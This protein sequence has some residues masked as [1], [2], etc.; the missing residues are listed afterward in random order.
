MAH[1]GNII[2]ILVF[3][4]RAMRN[5]VLS[6]MF[7]VLCIGNIFC[8]AW[9]LSRHFVEGVFDWNFRLHSRPVCFFHSLLT[10][11][12]MSFCN[13]LIVCITSLRLF[14]MI[15]PDRSKRNTSWKFVASISTVLT[16]FTFIA[17]GYT[18]DIGSAITVDSNTG[19]LT[20]CELT[21][22]DIYSHISMS[23]FG[24]VP[25]ILLFVLNIAIVGVHRYQA[26][27]Q[28]KHRK[29]S[30]GFAIAAVVYYLGCATNIVIYCF[31]GSIFRHELWKLLRPM[32]KLI[33]LT[34][35]VASVSPSAEASS[36]IPAERARMEPGEEADVNAPHQAMSSGELM[37]TATGPGFKPESFSSGGFMSDGGYNDTSYYREMIQESN[38]RTADK[39]MLIIFSGTLISIGIPGNMLSFRVLRSLYIKR[40]ITF[41]GMTTL[42][43]TNVLALVWGPGMILVMDISELS[44]K[45]KSYGICLLYNWVTY[46]LISLSSWMYVLLIGLRTMRWAGESSMEA[47]DKLVGL[48]IGFLVVLVFGLQAM[49][50]Y[51]NTTY[52]IGSHVHTRCQSSLSNTWRLVNFFS[53]AISPALVLFLINI[54]AFFM[55]LDKLDGLLRTRV[56][57]QV[58]FLLVL[59]N[60]CFMISYLPYAIFAV[61]VVRT[62]TRQTVF[63]E[64]RSTMGFNITYLLLYFNNATSYLLF[65]LFGGKFRKHMK[66]VMYPIRKASLVA[67][68]HNV[69]YWNFS[70]PNYT[71]LKK[72]GGHEHSH[73][74]RGTSASSDETTALDWRAPKKSRYTVA[75]EVKHK[76]TPV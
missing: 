8:L 4:R 69:L 67:C 47:P 7:I 9:G 71:A 25:G 10:M 43:V 15:N 33:Y 32:R 66:F 59:S 2:T 19:A 40:N 23:I 34:G 13:W 64:V 21:R 70:A 5:N 74:P 46:S 68:M 72:H 42:C 35:G 41:Y 48:K 29:A 20:M 6:K 49:I 45:E 27:E 62:Y 76:N 11:S 14:Y 65:C 18:V 57:Y 39:V 52:Q 38:L 63:E 22:G 12:G 17:H 44:F 1:A 53:F 16:V 55:K 36:R 28:M 24:F 54:K 60:I 61:L 56:N 37:R 75:I 30:K 3:K 50:S 51:Y 26:P 31:V 73:K 58:T